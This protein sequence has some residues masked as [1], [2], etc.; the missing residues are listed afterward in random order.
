[1]KR[2]EFIAGLGS[3]VAWPVAAPAPQLGMRRVGLLMPYLENDPY[4]QAGLKVFLAELQK[5][6]WVDGRNV[7]FDYRWAGADPERMR[8]DAA[9]L[10][11]LVP[12]VILTSTNQSASIL[13]QQT[14]TI[15]IVF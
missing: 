3:A 12:D 13:G 9:E 1:M 2:R 11:G 8:A 6:G 15:P 5:L 14:R 4:R 7:R 10:I